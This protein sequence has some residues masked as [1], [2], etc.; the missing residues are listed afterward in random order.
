M[1]SKTFKV[2]DEIR[3]GECSGT[4]YAIE[5]LTTKIVE[6]D[7]HGRL[8]GKI[9]TIPHSAVLTSSILTWANPPLRW[10]SLSFSLAYE[11]DLKYVR[12]IMLGAVKNMLEEQKMGSGFQSMERFYGKIGFNRGK[13][14]SDLCVSFAS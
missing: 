13:T 6:L 1:S 3:I 5:Y 9:L 14:N 4:V 10:D 2:G 7:E 8:S 12:E 11:S